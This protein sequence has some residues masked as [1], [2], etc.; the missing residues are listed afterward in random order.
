MS[1]KH[2]FLIAV[3][4]ILGCA[5]G[6]TSG[7]PGAPRRGS[8]LTAEEIAG[9]HA[10]TGTAYDAIARLRPNWLVPRGVAAQGSEYA[11]V[12][13]DG[14]QHGDLN[15]LRSIPAYHVAEARYYDITQAGARYGIRG[16]T[17]G[18]ID[19]RMKVRE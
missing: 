5:A 19:V 15:S 4:A 18:V 7:A 8:A 13:V 2:F 3:A 17:G 12:F 1:I 16:G 6:G 11:V 14:N 10:N 9:E